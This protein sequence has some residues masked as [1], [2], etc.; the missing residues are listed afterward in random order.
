MNYEHNNRFDYFEDTKTYKLYII[1]SIDENMVFDHPDCEVLILDWCLDTE[2]TI[3]DIREDPINGVYGYDMTL[4]DSLFPQFEVL[5]KCI[6]NQLQNIKKMRIK[7]YEFDN[8]FLNIDLKY[9]HPYLQNNQVFLEWYNSQRNF[10]FANIISYLSNLKE[11][12][13][14]DICENNV[15]NNVIRDQYDEYTEY[16][17]W[18]KMPKL[19]LCPWGRRPANK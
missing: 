6:N 10:R 12:E 2:H 15:E 16:N 19:K 5:L 11:I 4:T 8:R 3:D 14:I 1:R 13:F 17:I 7:Y 18:N 9:L